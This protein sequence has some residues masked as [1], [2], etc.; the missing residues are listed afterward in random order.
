MPVPIYNGV[1]YQPEYYCSDF[2]K[3]LNLLPNNKY[4]KSY[5]LKR[6]CNVLECKWSRYKL[7]NNILEILKKN[8]IEFNQWSTDVTIRY[9][10]SII[11]SLKRVKFSNT[12]II[13]LRIYEEGLVVND[14]DI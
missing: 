7:D 4:Y 14:I 9:L 6:L 5:L 10:N 13:I 8:N 1:K 3:Y 12:D 2:C 11:S